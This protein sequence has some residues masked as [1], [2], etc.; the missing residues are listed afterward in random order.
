MHLIVYSVHRVYHRS[1]S[2]RALDISSLLLMTLERESEGF[3]EQTN[4]RLKK[5]SQILS[6][7]ESDNSDIEFDDTQIETPK[8]IRES[9]RN[10]L[11]R[12]TTTSVPLNDAPSSLKAKTPNKFIPHAFSELEIIANE[13]LIS[14]DNQF[15]PHA[16]SGSPSRIPRLLWSSEKAKRADDDVNVSKKRSVSDEEFESSD[17]EESVPKRSINPE[18]LETKSR[19]MALALARSPRKSS[20]LKNE[21]IP[22]GSSSISLHEESERTITPKEK[23]VYD[24]LRSIT[25]SM[26]RLRKDESEDEVEGDNDQFEEM[27]D[28]GLSDDEDVSLHKLDNLLPSKRRFLSDTGTSSSQQAPPSSLESEINP[29]TDFVNRLSTPRLPSTSKV[30]RSSSEDIEPAND[31]SP[32]RVGKL[33]R[34]R[35]GRLNPKSLRAKANKAN[36][37]KKQKID[38]PNWSLEK[39]DKLIRLVRLSIPNDVIA[40]SNLVV[41]ELG[42]QNKAELAKRVDFLEKYLE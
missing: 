3:R 27:A 25:S 23:K 40:S 26:E 4:E 18:D 17:E 9:S 42:C 6:P 1:V 13:K 24:L 36:D 29:F 11:I 21:V 28:P 16:V 7:S 20:P 19:D 37:T 22:S 10:M 35:R 39:W 2:H 32:R 15:T 38:Y 8:A 30:D 5:A 41:R 31:G 33:P 34:A 14:D 12:T